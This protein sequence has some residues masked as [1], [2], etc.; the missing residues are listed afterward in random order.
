MTSCF[1]GSESGRCLV[2]RFVPQTRFIDP[3]FVVWIFCATTNAFGPLVHSNWQFLQVTPRCVYHLPMRMRPMASLQMMSL[4]RQTTRLMQWSVNTRAIIDFKRHGSPDLWGTWATNMLEMAPFRA[5]KWMTLIQRFCGLSSL[6]SLP[7][8]FGIRSSM[9][10]SEGR[11]V[12]L[13]CV[14]SCVPSVIE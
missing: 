3:G 11:V 13:N 14:P 1:R 2:K 9:E 8:K 7:V 5:Q 10:M 12:W 4:W 6:A